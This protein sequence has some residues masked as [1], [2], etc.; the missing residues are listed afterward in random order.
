MLPKAKTHDW[1]LFASRNPWSGVLASDDYASP[2]M[3][4]AAR[5]RFYAT[6]ETDIA[7]LL[8]WFEADFGIKPSGRALDIG[9]GQGW[10]GPRHGEGRPRCFGV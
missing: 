4:A 5:R 9:G 2:K 8:G 10:R 7:W 3:D 1:E 6:G